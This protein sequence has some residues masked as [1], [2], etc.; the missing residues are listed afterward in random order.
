[1]NKKK[2]QQRSCTKVVELDDTRGKGTADPS[3]EKK[4]KEGRGGTT[5]AGEE[6]G[7]HLG[8]TAVKNKK[9]AAAACVTCTPV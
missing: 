7:E 5:A 6:D 8:I 1:M 9:A 2:K 4:A 3:R